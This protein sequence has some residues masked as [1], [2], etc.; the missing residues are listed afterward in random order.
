VLE[1]LNAA[2]KDYPFLFQLYINKERSKTEELLRTINSR[3]QIKAI[4]V[5]VDLPVVSK[6]E[7]DERIKLDTL[8]SSGLGGATAGSDAKGSGLARSVGSFIDPSF[9]WED[10]AWLRKQTKL[11]IV[12]KGIQCAADARI[13]MHM[14]CQGI[15][16][17]NHGGRALDSAPGSIL[18]LLE[19]HRE[20]AEVFDHM[21][22]FIDGGVR[23]GSD[24]LKA[25]CLGASGVGIGRPF[26]Y[27]INYG[28]EGVQHA[29][30]SELHGPCCCF[31]RML[32][33]CLVLKDE[34]ETA[35]RL[36][37]LKTLD[38]ADPS[39]VNTAEVDLL[40]PRGSLHPYARK[41]IGPRKQYKL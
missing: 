25:L 8:Y 41:R 33:A 12:L 29:V 36:V 13:A 23:R 14:G 3:P 30:N 21:D 5:T 35:M 9:C 22:V 10:L 15:V 28:T 11:P 31:Y 32:T 27:A 38:N 1:I 34:V 40:V 18:V 2:P 37:G 20:C 4:F 24:V 6:R 17:S 16:V 19:L 7:A 26:Q 39:L